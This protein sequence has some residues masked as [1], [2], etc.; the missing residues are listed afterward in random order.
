MK[1]NAILIYGPRKGGTTL[2]QR[3]VDGTTIWVHPTELK[4]KYFSAARWHNT[5]ELIAQYG[6]LNR[7]LRGCFEGFDHDRY[8]KEID[9]RTAEAKCLRDII[10]SDVETAVQC[11]PGGQW[12]GWAVKEVGG[13]LDTVLHDWKKMFPE[14]KIVMI[15]RNPFLV[16][17]SVF[18]DRR[19][20]GRQLDLRTVVREIVRPWRTIEA[21]GRYVTRPDV[22][23]VYYEDIVADTETQMRA[24]A[25][26]L[27]ID[28]VPA[29]SR[30]TLFGQPTVVRTAS[31]QEETVFRERPP[32]W[33]GLNAKEAV[34]LAL[35][36]GALLAKDLLQ[37][38]VKF[39]KGILRL[40]V[41]GCH[42]SS[43]DVRALSPRL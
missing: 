1:E 19:R 17:R 27:G 10:L 14:S 13:R 22:H 6:R 3:L 7:I 26:F 42:R 37:R 20:K 15:F 35:L 36:G 39:D 4:I 9:P 5:P 32:F 33:S 30:P 11:S 25:R 31:R 43:S 29:L 41:A 23:L 8:R 24:V 40:A 2:L 18:R 28:F 12:T 34:L 16:S 38:K 21:M